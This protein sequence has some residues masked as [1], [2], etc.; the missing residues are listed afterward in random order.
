LQTLNGHTGRVFSVTFSPDSN[1][2]ASASGDNKVKLWKR[3]G[4]LHQTISGH[5]DWIN[6]VSFS[7][8]GQTIATASNDKTVRLWSSSN[9]NEIRRFTD[10]KTQEK[11]AHND[12]VTSV[13]F[14]PDKTIATSSAD[15][16]VK[17]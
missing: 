10:I 5:K 3:D 4:N 2:I 6:S 13:S 1:L 9:G 11:T 7:P 16:T 17:L 8:D 14:S 15:R 12:T